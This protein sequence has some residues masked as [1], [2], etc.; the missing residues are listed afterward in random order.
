MPIPPLAHAG[1][2]SLETSKLQ[3]VYD[4]PGKDE[5]RREKRFLSGF[6]RGFLYGAGVFLIHLAH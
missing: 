6:F 4:I 5:F 2:I 1:S 3:G